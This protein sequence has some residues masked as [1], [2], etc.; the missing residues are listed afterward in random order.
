MG[1]LYGPSYLFVSFAP[2][3][4]LV[5]VFLTEGQQALKKRTDHIPR[6]A[7]SFFESLLAHPFSY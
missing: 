7:G 6:V 2:K 3:G 4:E 1:W 5:R